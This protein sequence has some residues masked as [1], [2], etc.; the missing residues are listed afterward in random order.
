MSHA[1]AVSLMILVTLLWSIAGVVTRHLDAAR[2]FEVTFWRSLFNALALA[3]ALTALRGPALWRGLARWPRAVWISG[4]CWAVMFTAFMVAITLT[5]VANVLVTMAVGPLVTALF[6]RLFLHHRLPARTWAAI[7]LAGL[8][9]AWMFGQEAQAGTSLTGTLVALAV[10]LAAA[11]NW[12]MLQHIGERQ[13]ATPDALPQ[14]MLPAVW[15]G[16][17]LS[18]LATLPLAWPLQA[19]GHDLGLLA[20]L[21]GVQLAIPCLLVVRLSRVLPAPEI[22]LLAL[23]EVVFGVAWAWLGAGEQPAT[24]TLAGGALVLAAL[25]GNEALALRERRGRR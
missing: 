2:S 9:I 19:S 7:A 12:T 1:R 16:A 13:A 14:D 6:S 3:V 15:V 4:V 8:G 10:P 18:A 20:L 25:V 11:V 21:G 24:S 22:A 17:M 5:T 23:L